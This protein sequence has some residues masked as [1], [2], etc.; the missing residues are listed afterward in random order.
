[1]K[2]VILVAAFVAMAVAVRWWLLATFGRRADGQRRR[3]LEQAARPATAKQRLAERAALPV[4]LILVAAVAILGVLVGS[5]V[6][7]H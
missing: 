5:W 7:P 6:G 2:T 3:G 1:M 4:F